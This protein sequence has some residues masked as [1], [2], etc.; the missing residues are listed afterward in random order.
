M[1]EVTWDRHTFQLPT[2]LPSNAT[3]AQRNQYYRLTVDGL[4]AAT[5]APPSMKV[6]LLAS[7]FDYAHALRETDGSLQGLYDDNIQGPVILIGAP[8]NTFVFFLPQPA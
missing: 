6:N 5:R 2:R 1:T 3:P 4:A 7:R 8:H